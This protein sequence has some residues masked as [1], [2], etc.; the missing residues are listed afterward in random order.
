M[1]KLNMDDNVEEIITNIINELDKLKDMDI[2]C[3][4][5]LDSMSYL[6]YDVVNIDMCVYL[7]GNIEYIDKFIRSCHKYEKLL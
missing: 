5:R 3:M 6:D 2:N 4:V 1:K 7:S